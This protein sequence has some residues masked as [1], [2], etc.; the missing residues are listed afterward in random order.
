MTRPA[1]LEP[2]TS[3][4]SEQRSHPASSGRK[5]FLVFP[6][7]RSRCV[8]RWDSTEVR[9]AGW[10]AASDARLRRRPA[11]PAV[12]GAGRG[13]EEPPAGV[14]PTLRPY[15]GRVLAVDTT[16]ACLDGMETAGVEPAPP[17][18]KRGAPPPELHPHVGREAALQGSSRGR[19]SAPA[20]SRPCASKTVWTGG[21][22]PPQ[23]EA[24]R[25]QRAELALAQRPHVIGL[26][27]AKRPFRGLCAVGNLL[28]QILDLRRQTGWPAGFEPVPRGSRPRMLPLHHSHHGAGTTGLEP[29]VY[30]LTTGCSCR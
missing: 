5:R 25:L 24:T 23:P 14:E 21:V 6:A 3:A 27:A 8:G 28:P 17:R 19:E 22:E 9:P 4:F 13:H 18:C 30:R 7:R 12:G 1:G 15:K 11:P 29:A 16:E 20:D 10:S 2:A 26:A